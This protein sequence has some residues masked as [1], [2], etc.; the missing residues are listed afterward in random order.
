MK[1]QEREIPED[2]DQ[3]AVNAT[4]NWAVRHPRPNSV[5]GFI[6]STAI[7]PLELAA[8]CVVGTRI[9]RMQLESF[10]C[11]LNDRPEITPEE[12]LRRIAPPLPFEI[13][14]QG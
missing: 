3:R 2:F 6:G 11:L 14:E 8:H 10:H 9:G 1:P 13:N 5:F 7:T 12:L 4:V